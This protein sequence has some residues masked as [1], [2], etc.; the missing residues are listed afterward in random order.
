M[1]TVTITFSESGPCYVAQAGL[2]L[3]GTSDHI[4]SPNNWDYR[5]ATTSVSK[6]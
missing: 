6:S 3:L 2:E 5:C 4:S 1:M